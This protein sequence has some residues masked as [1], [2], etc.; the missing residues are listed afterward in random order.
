MEKII[1]SGA[2]GFLGTEIVRTLKNSNYEIY[3]LTLQTEKLANKMK[4]TKVHIVCS[5]GFDESIFSGNYC[6]VNCAYPMI[7]SNDKIAE[8]FNYIKKMFKLLKDNPPLFAI[9]VSSQSVYGNHRKEVANEHT[10]ALLEDSYSVGKY[11]IELLFDSYCETIRHINLRMAGL[12][13]YKTEVGTINKILKN[14]IKGE[15]VS[16]YGGDQ[17]L[18]YIDVIDAAEGIKN[19]IENYEVFDSGNYNFGTGNNFTLKELVYIIKQI[20]EKYG[21][22]FEV[23]FF[24]GNY[25][26]NRAINCD[27]LFEVI[28]WRPR[29]SIEQSIDY[30]ID[31]SRVEYVKKA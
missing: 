29:I 8:G 13:G 12:I 5:N 19:I 14:V 15:D 31:K 24:D 4:N 7:C 9:N 22:M 28:N 16:V 18:Q 1:I 20:A 11:L 6:F 3:A 27:K 2:G 23:N 10:M 30:I 17:I 25:S 21:I 26:I